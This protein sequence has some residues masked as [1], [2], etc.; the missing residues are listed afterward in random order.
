MAKSDYEK[1]SEVLVLDSDTGIRGVY[2][3][4]SGRWQAQ[5]CGKVLGTFDTKAE[6]AECRRKAFENA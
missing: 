4:K 1:F 3:Q 5:P 2:P 6:A